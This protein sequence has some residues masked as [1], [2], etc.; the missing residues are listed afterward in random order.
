MREIISEIE[1]EVRLRKVSTNMPI[2][3]I[4]FD[5][6]VFH[7]YRQHMRILPVSK[8]VA[9]MALTGRDTGRGDLAY[10]IC[11]NIK[12]GTL[13]SRTSFDFYSSLPSP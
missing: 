11:Q 3:R 12:E 2:N 5:R 4:L 7:R 8:D 9:R 6:A 10:S 1:K 13:V